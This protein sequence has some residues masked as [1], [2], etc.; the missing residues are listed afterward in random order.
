VG[1]K[2]VDGGPS[3]TVEVDIWLLESPAEKIG[4]E[5]TFSPTV[6]GRK[7]EGGSKS[8]G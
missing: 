4:K 6:I 1:A 2:G 5:V 7:G 3:V 8:V